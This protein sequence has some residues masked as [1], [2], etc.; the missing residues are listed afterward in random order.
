MFEPSLTLKDVYLPKT[1]DELYEAYGLQKS[2]SCD[3]PEP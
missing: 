2:V 1:Y 3:T